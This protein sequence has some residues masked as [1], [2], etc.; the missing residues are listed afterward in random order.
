MSCLSGVCLVKH[1]CV[2]LV[3]LRICYIYIYGNQRR[4]GVDRQMHEIF[5]PYIGEVDFIQVPI[6]RPGAGEV[7][8]YTEEK[9][10]FE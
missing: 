1:L 7:S 3:F 5:V 8:G 10:H 9:L 2:G 4:Q 6:P